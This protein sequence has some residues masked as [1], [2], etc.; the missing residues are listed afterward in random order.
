MTTIETQI[1]SEKL[2]D[3]V[4]DSIKGQNSQSLQ[5]LIDG[6]RAADVADLIE[7]LNP[8]ERLYLFDILEPEGAGEVLVEI[9]APVHELLG[10]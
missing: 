9:E 7:H 2:I 8:D 4:K 3:D 6:M 1:I 5:N 10:L